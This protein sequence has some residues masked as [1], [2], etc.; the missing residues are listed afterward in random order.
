M[1]DEVL[2]LNHNYQPLNVTN[3]QRAIVLLYLGKAHAVE[4]GER[5]TVVRLNHFVRRPT[6][7]LRPTRK[8]IFTRDGYR[9]A[10]CGASNAPLTIDHIVPRVRGGTNEW[11]NLVCCCTHCNNLKG[12]RTLEDVGMALHVVPRRPKCLP[13]ITYHKFVAALRNPEW[14]DYLAPY[15]GSVA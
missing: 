12:D 8:S 2:V 6:P 13:Y 4:N 11:E 14:Q 3:R 10:Y 1:S 5:P 15:A 7:I 9:C